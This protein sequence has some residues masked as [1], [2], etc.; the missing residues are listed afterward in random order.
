MPWKQGKTGVGLNDGTALSREFLRE[1][2]S[3]QMMVV[4]WDWGLLERLIP[5]KVCEQVLSPGQGL[6]PLT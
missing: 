3:G 2:R 1:L 4:L 5:T 6:V